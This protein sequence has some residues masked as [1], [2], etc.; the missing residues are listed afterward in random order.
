MKAI[1]DT[2]TLISFA[3]INFLELLE[4]LNKNILIP[5]IVYYEA[6]IKGEAKALANAIAIKNFIKNIDMKV[7]V[8]KD[9]YLKLLRSKITKTLAHGD[10]A[11]LAL[12]LQEKAGEVIT[13]DDG[14]GRIAMSMNFHVKASPD[15]LLE[16]L[17]TKVATL[18]DYENFLRSLAVENRITSVIADFYIMEGK[19][20]AKD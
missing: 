15:L 3:K 11:V 8:V 2:S 14:L 1:V 10:E 12:A 5:E 20:Y 13:N 4:K 17:K 19:K 6:V 7:H 9:E 18:K 16:G